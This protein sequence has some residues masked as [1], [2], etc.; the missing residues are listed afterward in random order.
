VGSQ[1]VIHPIIG[2]LVYRLIARPG[3]E[4]YQ[5]VEYLLRL[6]VF[7]HEDHQGFQAD[8]H[9]FLPAIFRIALAGYLPPVIEDEA[10]GG[11]RAILPLRGEFIGGINWDQGGWGGIG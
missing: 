11:R 1:Q 9:T 6:G 7:I 3:S 2:W 8:G 10:G 5:L 4:F